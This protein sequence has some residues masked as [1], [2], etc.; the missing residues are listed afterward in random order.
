MKK[1][2]SFLII[3]L[4]FGFNGYAQLPYMEDFS[5]GWFGT[6]TQFDVDG[7][8]EGFSSFNGH[9]SSFSFKNPDQFFPNN[10]VVSPPIDVTGATNL[11]LAYQAGSQFVGFSAELFT[12]Y[13]ST[14]NTVVDLGNPAITVSETVDL[15]LIPAADAALVGFNLDVSALDGAT[16][17]YIAFRHFYDDSTLEVLNIDDVVLTGTTLGLDDNVFAGF[18]YFVDARHV[19]QLSSSNKNLESITIFNLLGQT[20]LSNKLSLTNAS[21]DLSALNSGV[22]IAKVNIDGVSNSFKILKK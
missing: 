13:V 1:I 21:V 15:D 10:Y 16:T 11:S 2:T 19:L 9:M 3:L 14:G 8:G 6:W 20:V 12:V 17:V 7:D 4:T 22:Y 18:N 5:G